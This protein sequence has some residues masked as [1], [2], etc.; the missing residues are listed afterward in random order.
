MLEKPSAF[1]QTI[2]SV[3]LGILAPIGLVVWLLVRH[4]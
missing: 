1:A 2:L 4:R 3:T